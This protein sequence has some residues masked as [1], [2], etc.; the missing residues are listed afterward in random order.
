MS[1]QNSV[2]LGIV[3]SSYSFYPQSIIKELLI[4]TPHYL[5]LLGKLGFYAYFRPLATAGS[6]VL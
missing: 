6:Q 1:I 5:Y 3:M 4:N 2:T